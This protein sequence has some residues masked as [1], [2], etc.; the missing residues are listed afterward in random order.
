M[1]R[2]TTVFFAALLA[3]CLLLGALPLTVSATLT[4][5]QSAGCVA[6]HLLQPVN[7]TA[8]RESKNLL[9]YLSS[10]TDTDRFIVGQFD[11]STSDDTWNNITNQFGVSPGL[12]SNR[13]VFNHKYGETA[14]SGLQI[15]FSNVEQANSLLEKH[16]KQGAVLLVHA[17]QFE[18]Q[19]YIS[20]IGIASGRYT[21]DWNMIEQLDETNPDRDMELYNIWVQYCEAYIEC[22][23]DLES[24]GVNAY[25]MRPFVE[26]NYKDFCG[27]TPGAYPAFVRVYQQF[28]ERW[29]NSG[30]KGW[31]MTYSPGGMNDTFTRYPGNDYVD[32]VGVTCYCDDEIDGRRGLDGFI[33]YDWFRLTGKPIGF[34]ELSCR[35]GGGLA[36]RSSWFNLLQNVI[37]Q[38]PRISWVNC[39]GDS[40]F[41]LQDYNT[42][43]L[44]NAGQDDGKAF[45]CSPFT[46]TLDEVQNYQEGESLIPGIVQL[47]ES[48]DLTGKYIGMEEKLYTQAE[49]TA[50]GFSIDTLGSFHVNRGFGIQFYTGDNGEGDYWG[51]ANSLKNV[52][53]IGAGKPIR[54]IRI[55]RQRNAAL[56][57]D[58]M[59]YASDNDA[60]AVKAIDGVGSRWVGTSVPAWLMIDLG[61]SYT[62]NRYAVRHA[63]SSGEPM[64][65]NTRD[66]QFQYSVDGEN[67][68]TV[69]TVTGNTGNI[70]DRFVVPFTAQYVR[71]Y[72]TDPNSMTGKDAAISSVAEFEIY[73]IDSGKAYSAE[74]KPTPVIDETDK[75]EEPDGTTDEPTVD[76]PDDPLNPT[77]SDTDGDDAPRPGKRRRVTRTV[78]VGGFPTWALAVILIGAV[79]LV[80]GGLTLFLLLRKKKQNA[81]A[82]Q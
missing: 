18:V 6:D 27:K 78:T 67:W 2:L 35:S 13:Y 22:L 74:V 34:T 42:N 53:G 49:L 75:E 9:A 81:A 15:G 59:A 1:K 76:E 4:E 60:E 29:K 79:V 72:I 48:K 30:L 44:L 5:E 10:L 21:N 82:P 39:W 3:L 28:V 17:D 52:S 69:D 12:Y 7:P 8:S 50:L 14:E 77:D 40:S 54:S 37:N 68:I 32:V 63:G 65:Y 56:E 57:P 46:I 64:G 80:G 26:S 62:V 38:W 58:A 43:G 20:Q 70:T 55:V 45:M 16:Y 23:R 71:L 66:F 47:Y 31:L 36:P 33:D 73:G 51:Y 61:R 24:R 19:D 11:I 25:L 41:S